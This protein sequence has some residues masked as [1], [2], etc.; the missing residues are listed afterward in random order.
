MKGSHRI[1][2]IETY[3]FAKKLAEIRTLIA[4]GKDIINLGIGS[5]DI[6]TPNSIIEVLKNAAEEDGAG[7]YQ[8][9]K[10][11]AE[12][13][14]AFANWYSQVFDVH[15]NSET[16]ILPLMGSKESILHVHLAFC[17]PGDTVL[18]PNP[19]YPTYESSAKMV[20]VNVVHYNLT[21]EN[22][23]LP[24]MDELESLVN[25][26]CKVMWINY[27]HMPTGVNASKEDLEKLIRFAQKHQI[28]LVNDNPY[29]LILNDNP[30][31]IHAC[32]SD[33]KDVL[34]LNSL[35]KSHNM[36]GWRVGVVTGSKENID[37][38][39]KAKSNMDSGMYKPIQLAAVEALNLGNEWREKL[40]LEYK[41]RV[42]LVWQILDELN[43]TYNK[44]YTGLFVWSKV[45]EQY[46]NGRELSDQLLYDYDVFAAPGMVF[47][48]NGEKYIRFSLCAPIN[49]LKEALKRIQTKNVSGDEN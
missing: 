43:C 19:G 44:N 12:L 33:Y 38:L 5:P 25:N 1:S 30:L 34:E 17:D 21:E 20:G 42:E 24:S 31:S 22:G 39:L 48:S 11:I 13:R 49:Q 8:A 46:A 41:A 10:G 40:N 26:K 9:Y 47:G 16:E 37:L 27:P 7:K 6:D 4:Q 23:W 45:G 18:V 28:L 35:S 3:Y 36:S 2:T 32:E 14:E 15:L 29:G